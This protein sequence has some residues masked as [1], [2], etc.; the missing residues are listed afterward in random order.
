[1]KNTDKEVKKFLK[2]GGKITKLPDQPTPERN[3][4]PANSLFSVD[5]NIHF[6]YYE[7]EETLIIYNRLI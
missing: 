1:M 4:I 6:K 7:E 2:K 5:G 3:F